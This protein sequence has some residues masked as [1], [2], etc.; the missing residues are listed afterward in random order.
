[1]RAASRTPRASPGHLMA[2]VAEPEAHQPERA[3]VR[4]R[5]RG[6]DPR[7]AFGA[8]RNAG[9]EP[10]LPTPRPEPQRDTHGIH[11]QQQ[12]EHENPPSRLRPVDACPAQQHVEEPRVD[13][14]AEADRKREPGVPETPYEDEVETLGR[15]ETHDGDLDRGPDVLPRIKTGRE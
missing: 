5:P 11:G 2:E 14:R 3:E 9:H 12:L 8:L 7:E 1:M 10:V 13:A 4:A 15:D 6:D